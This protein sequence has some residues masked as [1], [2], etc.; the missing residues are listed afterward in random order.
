MPESH[1]QLDI[2]SM[3]SKRARSIDASGIR[4][5][6]ELGVKLKDPINLSIGQP[7]FPVPREIKDAVID[8]IESDKNGYTVTQGEASVLAVVR[9]HLAEEMG[10]DVD[11]ESIGV[12]LTSGTSGGLVLAA[13]AL[14]EEGDE[15]IIPDPWFV[16]YPQLARLTG[17]TLVTCDTYP[18]FRMTAERIESLITERTKAVIIDSPG[19]PTGV[20]L[21]SGELQAIVDLCRQRGVVLISDEIYDEFTFQDALEDGYCPS[22]ARISKDALIIKGLGKTFGCTGWR[23]GFAAGPKALIEEMTKLQQFTYVCAPSMAQQAFKARPHVD[24]KEEVA[25]YEGR[26]DLVMERLGAVTEVVVPGGAFYAFIKVPE[27]LG[28]SG[29]TFVERAIE[30]GVLIIPGAVFS[31]RDTHF[32]LSYAVA[33]DLLVRG[34]DILVDLMQG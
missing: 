1:T 22:P 30:R 19:N 4:R 7:D 33:E 11:D 16:L 15:L 10:W 23:L 17:A 2:A 31:D 6:F 25:S 28:I 13:M 5:I 32:R 9:E 29:T 26:R 12:M 24:M 8:A 18:D 34:L 14:L 3:L 21:D 27:H 20:V